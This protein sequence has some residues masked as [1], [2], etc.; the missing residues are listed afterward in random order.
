VPN[1]L[2]FGFNDNIQLTAAGDGNF[3]LAWQVVFDNGGSNPET[4]EIRLARFTSSTRTWSAA[5]T[6]V[7]VGAQ[8]DVRFH[9][10]GSDGRGNA[11]LLWTESEGMRTA[12]KAGRIAQAGASFSSMQVIDG[13]VGGGA[14]HADLAVDPSGHAIAIWQQFPGGRPDDGSR[15]NI[16][17]NRFDGGNNTWTGAEFTE[18]R[19]REGIGPRASASGGQALL[20]WI[21]TE[22]KDNRVKAQLQP[23]AGQ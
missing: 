14:A 20:V 23:L 13:A 8:N 18:K 2:V 16:A 15:S 7:P 12:L 4:F 17:I 6:V 1:S 11:L 3:L 9:R 10:I 19:A 22:G 21:E 5:Q